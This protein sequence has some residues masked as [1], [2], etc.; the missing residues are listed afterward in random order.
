MTHVENALSV[1]SLRVNL[2]LSLRHLPVRVDALETAV[3]MTHGFPQDCRGG[4][5]LQ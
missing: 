3:E 4:F 5:G 1:H 2:S